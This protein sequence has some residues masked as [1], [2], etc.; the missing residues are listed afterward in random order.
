MTT[1]TFNPTGADGPTS[2]QVVRIVHIGLVTSEIMGDLLKHLA[3]LTAL[4]DGAGFVP[5][6]LDD[7][8]SMTRQDV[9]QLSF[10]PLGT[11]RIGFAI[12]R[13]ASLPEVFVDMNDVQH[14][15]KARQCRQYV[16]LQ[17]LRAIGQGN[18]VADVPPVA[19]GGPTRQTLDR[20]RLAVP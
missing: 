11:F 15:R 16:F 14:Q 12:D 19:S 4:A 20:G 3:G 10:D 5:Q 7:K 2:L 6:A 1:N 13:G 9:Q 17:R 8:V 18:P